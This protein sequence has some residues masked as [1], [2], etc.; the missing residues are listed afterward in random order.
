MAFNVL[1]KYNAGMMSCI[2]QPRP[3]KLLERSLSRLSGERP[4]M[5][6]NTDRSR[7]R[8]IAWRPVMDGLLIDFGVR[9]SID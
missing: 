1:I 6:L 3:I 9:A 5:P 7:R 2:L 4:N 8:H